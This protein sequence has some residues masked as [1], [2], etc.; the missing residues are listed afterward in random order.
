MRLAALS[1]F[2]IGVR[3]YTDGFS[4]DLSAFGRFLDTLER[5]HDAIVLL[6]DIWQTDHATVPSRASAARHLRAARARLPELAQRLSEPP[7]IYVHGNHD[8]IAE[9]ELGA[10]HHV[11][12]DGALFIHGHQFDPVAT[13]APWAAAAGTWTTGQL[14]KTG[15]RSFA[16]WLEGRDITIKDRRFRGRQGPY[17][18]AS[19]QLAAQHEARFVVMGHTHVASRTPLGDGIVALNTGSCSRGQR[20]FVSIDTE[21]RVSHVFDGKRPL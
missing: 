21:T 19:R 3:G 4:H 5:D 1:D 13:A 11:C 16:S 2:H 8:L 17:A 7:Y 12:L 18:R 14:R 10:L 20:N 6:G 9:S 15:M